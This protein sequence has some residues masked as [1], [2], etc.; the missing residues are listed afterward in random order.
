MDKDPIIVVGGGLA[1][2]TCVAQLRERGFDGPLGLISAERHLPYERPPL[3][4]D[5][6]QGN[7][8]PADFTVKDEAWYREHEVQVQLG[9]TATGI[10]RDARKLQLSDGA[11]LDYGHLVLATGSRANPGKDIPGAQLPGVH[12]LRT[13][14]DA[15]ALRRTLL[16][17]TRIAIIGSGW[18]GMEAAASARQQR[19]EVTVISPS[20]L[21]LA[22]TLGQTFGNHLADLHR[23]AGVRLMLKTRVERI[24]RRENELVVH[25]GHRQV[26]AD[27]VLL[28]TGAIPNL[29][30]AQ[31]AQLETAD[32]VITDA[33]LRTSDSRILAIGDIAQA[34]NTRLRQ[35]LRVQ[36]WDNAIRQ[37]KL[38][39]ATLTGGQ[40]D[41]DWLPYF[42]TDQFGL[43]MEFV[44]HRKPDDPEVLRGSVEDGEFILF[45]LHGGR[46]SAA[47][48]VNTWDV[49]PALRALL[50]QQVDPARLADPGIGLDQLAGD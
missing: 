41:Y 11:S 1:G 2:A 16:E 20:R 40:E 8:E 30:L 49:N 27:T 28:A 36:H 13:V 35:Q 47:M 38:A 15:Q 10:D 5:Y 4:K 29:E 46:V 42:F 17:G 48:N 22:D 32:G 45:W 31:A 37:G 50:G 44:G 18:I 33:A 14:D 9:T 21:P 24:E 3:S 43:G 26:S 12:V 7:S 25:A 19:A 39:A 34:F 6:L 23:E